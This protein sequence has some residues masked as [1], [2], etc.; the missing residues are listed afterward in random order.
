[1]WPNCHEARD[2]RDS[3]DTGIKLC[4]VDDSVDVSSNLVE[5]CPIYRIPKSREAKECMQIL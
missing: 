5:Q 1:M 4:D 3:F 2:V